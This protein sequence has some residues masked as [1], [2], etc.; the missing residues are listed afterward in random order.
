MAFP[1]KLEYPGKDRAKEALVGA[2]K[3]HLQRSLHGWSLS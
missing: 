3:R 2:S 1:V